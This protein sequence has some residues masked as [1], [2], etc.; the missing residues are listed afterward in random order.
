MNR[1]TFLTWVGAGWL[2][3][4]MP[5]AI[6]AVLP[7][8]DDAPAFEGEAEPNL[9]AQAP[10]FQTV[11]TV[12]KLNQDGK[13]F[14]ETS[15]IGP[16]LIVRDPAKPNTLLAVNPKC[17]HMGCPVEWQAAKKNFYCECHESRFAANGK[18]LSGPAKQPLPSYEVKIHGNAIVARRK[19]KS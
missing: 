14:N 4:S 16:I 13:I 10:A 6:A 2:A 8:S 3:S 17:T 18:A 12:A 1:R 7:N 9:M 11:G 19:P 15:P 5:V